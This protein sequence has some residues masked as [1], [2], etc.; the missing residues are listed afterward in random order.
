MERN[1]ISKMIG[2]IWRQPIHLSLRQMRIVPLGLIISSQML[3]WEIVAHMKNL[4]G[5]EAAMAY[6][7]IAVTLITAIW[8]GIDSLHK[9]NQPDTDYDLEEEIARKTEKFEKRPYRRR[10][11][12]Q[13]KFSDEDAGSLEE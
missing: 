1:F 12:R 11:K 2:F 5:E 9:P 6:G 7:T 13:E 8:K 4:Q 3:V 10:T